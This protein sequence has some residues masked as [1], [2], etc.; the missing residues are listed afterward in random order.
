MSLKTFPTHPLT[1]RQ[2]KI[3]ENKSELGSRGWQPEALLSKQ[4]LSPG[5]VTR[6]RLNKRPIHIKVWLVVTGA[7]GRGWKRKG[8]ERGV[9]GESKLLG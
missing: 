8:T 2:K 6:Y 1:H 3:R 7:G 5:P 4:G 9:T